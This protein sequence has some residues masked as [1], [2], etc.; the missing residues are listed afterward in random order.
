MPPTTF[1]HD[2]ASDTDS[3]VL[4]GDG[5]SAMAEALESTPERIGVVDS[6]ADR[7]LARLEA[8]SNVLCLVAEHDPPA[9]DG[10]AMLREVRDRYPTLPIVLYVRHADEAVVETALDAG[11]T[12]VVDGS[13]EYADQ[14]AA[15]RVETIVS[16][17]RRA[18]TADTERD[19]TVTQSGPDPVVTVDTRGEI[20]Q[21]HNT[22]GRFGYDAASLVGEPISTLFPST[23]AVEALATDPVGTTDELIGT[24]RDGAEIP[25]SVTVTAVDDE[26]VTLLISAVED[27][28]SLTDFVAFALRDPDVDELLEAAARVVVTELGLSHATVSV[29]DVADPTCSLRASVGLPD[30][31]ADGT[32]FE[33][34]RGTPAAEIATVID[35]VFVDD[36]AESDQFD[37]PTVETD[38]DVAS[39]FAVSFPWRHALLGLLEGYAP[40]PRTFTEAERDFVGTIESTLS[41]VLGSEPRQFDPGR[42]LEWTTEGICVLDDDLRVT[43]AN[44]RAAR[45]LDV[46][47]SEMLGERLFDSFTTV[48]GVPFHDVCSEVRSTGD[49]VDVEIRLSDLDRWFDVHVTPIDSGVTVFFRNLVGREPQEQ[50]LW[51]LQDTIQRLGNAA[52]VEEISDLAV[53]AVTE[54]LPTSRA[55]TYLFDDEENALRSVVGDTATVGPGDDSPV[56]DAFVD[57]GTVTLHGDAV[58]GVSDARGVV[59]SPFGDYGVLVVELPESEAFDARVE[60]L[61]RL[62]ADVAEQS[63]DRLVR[64]QTLQEREWELEQQTNRLERFNQT[65]QKLLGVEKAVT[66]ADNREDLEAAVCDELVK[67]ER[68]SFVWIGRP[69]EETDSLVPRAWSGVE[70]GYFDRVD[71][72]LTPENTEPAVQAAWTRQTTHVANVSHGLRGESWRQELLNRG[73]QSVYSLPLVHDDT[74]HGVLTVCASVPDAFDDLSKSVFDEIADSTAYGIDAIEGKQALATDSVVELDVRIS[75]STDVFRRLARHV[76]GTISFEGVV[77]KPDGTSMLYLTAYGAESDAVLDYLHDSVSVADVDHI[78]D[79]ENGGLFVVTTSEPTLVS[80]LISAEAAIQKLEAS[81]T[82]TRFVV[83]LPRPTNVRSFLERLQE[84]HPSAE[85]LGRRSIERPIESRQTFMASLAERLTDRQREVLETAYFNGYF[86]WPRTRTG[87][88]IAELLGITQ[89]TFNNHLRVAERK[90]FTM[91]FERRGGGANGT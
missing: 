49:P 29:C 11:A 23:G 21:A 7:A 27:A 10:L 43:H 26:T 74:L 68:F 45:A 2:A 77:P 59:A 46:D 57:G 62:L 50:T 40:E 60:R 54:L 13:G 37:H 8:E 64:E 35:P 88:E 75:D 61:V 1:E 80:R 22:E 81:P 87:E 17:A 85:L 41:F 51:V 91:L 33:V 66:H 76:D 70:R 67:S 90:L 19:A 9:F 31:P 78:S 15:R 55:T 48:D 5:L 32:T 14:L 30:A 44:E 83:E 25:L 34:R 20:R 38:V 71:F 63:V 4:V 82:E 69:D 42:G 79:V 58:D 89:P 84:N 53:A 12:D 65:T 72:T 16:A 18:T 86:E 3:V 52:S 56:W 6:D 36:F 47:R 73:I 28:F 39:G 24:S